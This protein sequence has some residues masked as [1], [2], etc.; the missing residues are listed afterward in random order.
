MNPVY[1]PTLDG[2]RVLEIGHFVAAP[3]CARLLGDL[4]ADVI[5]I[6]PLKGDPVRQWGEQ[7]Y[8]RS[9]WW[10]I[11]GRNKRSL[12][13]DLKASEAREIVLRLV[14]SCDAVV[15]NFRP[16]QLEKLRSEEHT[17]ELQ[18]LMRIS[19]AVFCLKK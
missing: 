13:L 11:H 10:S 7:V 5:K 14:A 8:G 3:F 9:L 17:S 2:L 16:G 6:E 4:G 1:R 19:Y 15:E 18:S 12:A